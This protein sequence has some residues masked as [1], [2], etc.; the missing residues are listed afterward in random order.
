MFSKLTVPKLQEYLKERGITYSKCK[1]NDL[2][3]LCEQAY[4]AD[5]EIDP[6]C[7]KDSVR[8]FE[9]LFERLCNRADT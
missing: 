4:K 2:T 1:K 5:L 8:L 6:D 3:E 9:R 7:L